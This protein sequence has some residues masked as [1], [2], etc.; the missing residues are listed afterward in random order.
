M[1]R[2]WLDWDDRDTEWLE[3]GDAKRMIR[4]RW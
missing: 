3:G 2:G 1:Q 4:F